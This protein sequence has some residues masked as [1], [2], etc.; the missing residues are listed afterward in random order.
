M[1]NLPL[2]DAV[3]SAARSAANRLV[4]LFSGTTSD[5]D[6]G[7]NL[8]YG[9]L[10][11]GCS[12][13]LDASVGNGHT[14]EI[15]ASVNDQSFGPRKNRLALDAGP[16]EPLIGQF[17]TVVADVSVGAGSP[18]PPPPPLVTITLFQ[19]SARAPGKRLVLETM[20]VKGTFDTGTTIAQ[21]D[22]PIL[23]K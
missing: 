4:D 11:P 14:A 8:S 21:L 16:N 22:I 10:I 15:S 7:R 18:T 23:L 5:P 2:P 9:Y 19:Q 12:L 20:N 6:D 1:A 17:V 13:S 3:T